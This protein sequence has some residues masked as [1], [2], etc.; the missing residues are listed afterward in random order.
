MGYSWFPGNEQVHMFL[1][2]QILEVTS[3]FSNF[4]LVK[5][6]PETQVITSTTFPD[7]DSK[8]G[9]RCVILSG[10]WM[11]ACQS[12]KLSKSSTSHPVLHLVLPASHCLLQGK[13]M[14][15]LPGSSELWHFLIL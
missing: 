4:K 3:V 2:K 11:A 8:L 6:Y 1:E 5:I 15:F 12:E 13:G 10:R 9:K 7:S 14:F